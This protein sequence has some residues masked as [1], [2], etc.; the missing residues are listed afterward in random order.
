VFP[1]SHRP[2][3]LL[4]PRSDALRLWEA[5]ATEDRA[6]H[7]QTIHE[8][9]GVLCECFSM[10]ILI[11]LLMTV[12]SSRLSPSLNE[13]LYPLNRGQWIGTCE[14]VAGG[15]SGGERATLEHGE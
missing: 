4:E 3:T 15:D 7:E 14:R 13:G 11:V 9:P 8:A 5:M 2:S 10:H 12:L 6:S 1:P